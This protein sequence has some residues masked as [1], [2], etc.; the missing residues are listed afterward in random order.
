M[1]TAWIA[2]AIANIA[3]AATFCGVPAAR[4]AAAENNP[5]ARWIGSGLIAALG[6]KAL[7]LVV[8]VGGCWVLRHYDAPRWLVP[9]VV[10]VLALI[11]LYGAYTNV[12]FGWA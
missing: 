12:A 9:A 11:G 1:R 6:A 5:V 4:V 10:S 8:V 7:L 3:D 2:F